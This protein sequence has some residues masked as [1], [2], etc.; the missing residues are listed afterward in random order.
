MTRE[1]IGFD[2]LP[3]A[4]VLECLGCGLSVDI[5][6][7]S[8]WPRI[9][10]LPVWDRTEYLDALGVCPTCHAKQATAFVVPVEEPEREPQGSLFA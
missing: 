10:V 3:P 7:A 8:D 5:R 6:N 2:R 9:T 4:R 1:R